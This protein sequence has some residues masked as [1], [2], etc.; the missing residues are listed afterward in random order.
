MKAD[1]MKIQVDRIKSH[2]L[3]RMKFDLGCLNI[4]KIPV[5]FDIAHVHWIF[6][7]VLNGATGFYFSSQPNLSAIVVIFHQAI[8]RQKWQQLT[9]W[10][11]LQLKMTFIGFFILRIKC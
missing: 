4:S 7:P 3:Q 10:Q 9:E 8:L 6:F 5:D 11:M 1:S 2:W